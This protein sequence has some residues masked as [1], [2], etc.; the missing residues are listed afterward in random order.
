ML[1]QVS[2]IVNLTQVHLHNGDKRTNDGDKILVLIPT[3]PFPISITGTVRTQGTF[4]STE[5]VG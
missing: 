3:L 4:N 1:T 5:L 2:N